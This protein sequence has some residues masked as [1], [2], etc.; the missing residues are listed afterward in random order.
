[1]LYWIRVVLFPYFPYYRR[2]FFLVIGIIFTI[3]GLVGLFMAKP[4][5]QYTQVVNGKKV[6]VNIINYHF[7]LYVLGDIDCFNDHDR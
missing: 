7:Y 3:L 4:N 1:M 6:T 5:H 2:F